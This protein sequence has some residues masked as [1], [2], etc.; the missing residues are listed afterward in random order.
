MGG[1]GSISG[2]VVSKNF[3][4]FGGFSVTYTTDFEDT[5]PD[6]DTDGDGASGNPTFAIMYWN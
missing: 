6:L 3:Y 4:G 5:L 1:S 2:S